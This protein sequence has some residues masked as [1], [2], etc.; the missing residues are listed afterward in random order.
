MST[1]PDPIEPD[2]IEPQETE[3]HAIEPRGEEKLIPNE[4]ESA[5]PSEP[6]VILPLETP[7]EQPSSQTAAELQPSG[8]PA[9]ASFL[10]NYAPPEPPTRFPNFADL[11]VFILLAIFGWV[12]S[13]A[14]FGIA[15][16]FHLFGVTS[17]KQALTEIHYT[18]GTQAIWYLF[19]IAG[20]LFMFPPIW[21]KGFF[22]GVEWRG[23]IALRMR[24][25]LFAAAL[26]CFGLA[27]ADS[28][29]IPGPSDTPIDQI[30]RMPGA[31]WLLFGF[32][33]TLAPFFEELA[34]RGFLLPAVCTAWD[35]VNERLAKRPAPWP[36]P[37]GKT[38]WSL[39]SMA[40][41]SVLTSIPFA[42]MHAEQTVYSLGPFLLL[43][44]VSLVPCWVR[45]ST[46]SLAASTI[47]HSS[48]N[49]LLFSLMLAGTGGFKH[50]DKM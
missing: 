29:L 11:G 14:L 13:L 30:F 40:V 32:G 12:G 7:A 27:I 23:M 43:V 41:A 50:L 28:I 26:V 36:D 3:P 24:W 1:L 38:Q 48:Y 47:V 9:A 46:R 45:L 25:R 31:A 37:D 19:A 8:E 4:A 15:L 10:A 39:S 33:V 21:N 44:T 35:W 18:L 34:F 2:E 20:C 16:H 22:A 49:F 42:L 6:A 17:V 5:P